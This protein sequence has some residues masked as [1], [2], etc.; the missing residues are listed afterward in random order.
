MA[1]AFFPVALTS[2]ILLST[3]LN[4]LVVFAMMKARNK[5]TFRD[6]IHLSV[7]LSDMIQG[8]LGYPLEVIS[9]LEGKWQFGDAAC[10]G[11]AFMVTW[12]G[13]VSISHLVAMAIDRCLTICKPF[14]AHVLHQKRIDALYFV[15]PSWLYGFFWAFTP[16]V[17]WG[18]Y[19]NEGLARCS[20]DWRVTDP[21]GVSYIISLFVFCFVLPVAVMLMSF[22]AI[23]FELRKMRHRSKSHFGEDSESVKRDLKAEK[24]NNRLVAIMIT[25]FVAAWTPYSVISLSHSINAGLNLSNQIEQLAALFAKSSCTFNPI[26]YTFFY[27]E[28]RKYLRDFCVGCC[29]CA[30]NLNIIRPE[31]TSVS[32]PTTQAVTAANA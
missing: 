7:A 28:F 31:Q 30:M 1:V 8:I 3:M 13:L 22:A 16:L 6:I 12:L 25:A 19:A 17:G 10:A 29:P 20:I 5:L 18:G 23:R 9:V 32:A 14:T 15:I 27:K 24:K 4:G 26:I 2:V 21:I 11:T